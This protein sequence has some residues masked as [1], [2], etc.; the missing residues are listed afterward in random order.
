MGLPPELRELLAC[1]RCKGGLEEREDPPG[2]ICH[3]CGLFYEIRE[4]I[5]VLLVE[6]ARPLAEVLPD[7]PSPQAP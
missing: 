4:G 1:P 3:P 6:E 7:E 2:L 5:P